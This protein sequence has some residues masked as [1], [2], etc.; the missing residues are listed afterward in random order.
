MSAKEVAKYLR[1]NEKRV[2]RL[3][4]EGRIP[5]L[6]IGG[7]IGFPKELIDKWILETAQEE[8]NIYLAGSDDPLLK[9]IIDV[10]N[11]GTTDSVVFYAPV[12]SINGL[13]MLR[14]MKA[15]VASCHILDVERRD[16]SPSYVERYLGRGDYVVVELFGRR[17]GLYVQKGNPKGIRSLRDLASKKVYFVNRNRGSGTRLL[18]DFLLREEGVEENLLVGSEREVDS[19]L[20]A[21]LFVLKGYADCA[22]GIEYVASM[23]ELDFIPLFSERFDLVMPKE[24]YLRPQLKRFLSLFEQPSLSSLC[25]DLRGY[26]TTRSGRIVKI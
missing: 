21:G 3:V 2:Y 9:L 14:E 26:D 17:Q 5:H 12:G 13:K 23:L 25:R 6:K 8:G 19:H 22:F 4:R 10:H 7:K 18:F 11:K 16:Y 15:K 1:I 24:E 20:Q